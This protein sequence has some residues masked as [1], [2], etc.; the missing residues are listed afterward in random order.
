MKFIKSK[1]GFTLVELIVIIAVSAIVL[2][3]FSLLM[4]ASLRNEVAVNKTIDAQHKTQSAFMAINELARGAGFEEVELDISYLSYG[5]AI[6]LG[7]KVVYFDN[8]NH[9]LMYRVY[10]DDVT[11]TSS[12]IELSDYVHDVIFALD[13]TSLDIVLEIDKYNDSDDT[14]NEIFNYK[15]S[16]RE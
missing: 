12:E 16:K 13:E 3:P 15:F 6:R 4:T 1:Y 5:T 10:L 14:N 9:K 11:D 2:T 7:T 8:A